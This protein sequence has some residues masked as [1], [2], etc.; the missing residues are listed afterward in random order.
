[1]L[2]NSKNQLNLQHNQCC[3]LSFVYLNYNLYMNN[4]Q[5]LITN[6]LKPSLYIRSYK[7]LNVASLKRHGIKLLICDLDNTLVPHFTK[8]P[9]MEV[10]EFIHSVEKQGIEFVIMSNNT[11]KRVK[12][13]AEKA[14]VKEWYGNARKP[15]KKI[16]KSIIENKNLNPKDVVIMG[17]QI[18]MDILVANRLKCESI[19]VQPLVSSDVEM[20]KFNVFLENRIYN[21]LERKN[22]LKQGRFTT[23]K[24]N[25]DINLL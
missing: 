15:F 14:G 24:N 3:L 12:T 13:F 16:A 23:W 1:M 22:I 11:R 20:N 25:K 9:N 2:E 6:Y 19:L 10:I 7:E 21:N 5:G 8:L 18:I 4:R 17:D